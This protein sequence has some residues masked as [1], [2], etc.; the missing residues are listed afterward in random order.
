M[1]SSGSGSDWPDEMAGHDNSTRASSYPTSPPRHESSSTRLHAPGGVD[2]R[3]VWQMLRERRRFVFTVAAAVFALVMGYTA[4]SGMTFQAKGQLYLG[5]LDFNRYQQQRSEDFLSGGQGDVYSEIEIVRSRARVEQ[6]ILRSGLNVSI[7]PAESRTLPYWRWRWSRRD[8]GLLDARATVVASD[9]LPKSRAQETLVLRLRFAEL[10]RY[11]VYSEAGAEL[12]RGELGKPCDVPVAR[13]FL[14]AGPNGGPQPHS[15]YRVEIKPL[16][17][18]V[19]DAL[20]Q[21]Q[22]TAP[23][24]PT[25]SEPVKVLTL[26]F[27]DTSPHKA[28]AF[29]QQLMRVYLQERQS[30]KTED[31][32]AAESFVSKQLEGIQRSLGATEDRLADFR[33]KNQAVVQASQADAVVEQLAAYEQQRIA[34]RLSAKALRDIQQALQAPEPDVEK[35][36]IGEVEDTVLAQLAGGLVDA[37]RSLREMKSRLYDEAPEF[38]TQRTKVATQ[39]DMTRNYVSTRLARA[40]EQVHALDAVIKQYE[41]KLQAVPGAELGLAKIGR[42]SE[43][44]SRIYSYLLERQQQTQILKASTVSKNRILDAPEVPVREHSPKLAL[45]S[46]SALLGLLLGAIL[47]I[48]QALWSSAMRTA[49]EVRAALEHV[50]VFA[51]VPLQTRPAGRT[52]RL[53]ATPLFDVLARTRDNFGFA[54]AFRTLRTEI[55]DAQPYGPAKLVPVTSPSPGDGKTTTALALA[56][57]L[58][59]DRKRVLVIDADVRK[60]SHH[61]LTGHAAAPGLAEL[62]AGTCSESDATRAVHVTG[63]CFHSI[64]AGDGPAVELLSST[65]LSELLLRVRQHYDYVILDAASYPLVSDAL[66]LARHCEF[67]LSVIRLGKTSRR[68]AE[69]HYRGLVGKSATHALV[70]NDSDVVMGFGYPEYARAGGAVHAKPPRRQAR[71]AEREREEEKGAQLQ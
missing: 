8:P 53:A 30:W 3:H 63:G 44:Y 56:T 31:A 10:P 18:T 9:T 37:Q 48:V 41:E 70:I 2:A 7:T 47:V 58:A 50:P 62:L 36:L 25:A 22:V 66:I 28:A 39:L 20:R 71:T 57:I 35:F 16:A 64:P 40:Q 6:A 17:T 51:N 67:A 55:Y 42:E 12:G 38:V 4:L 43:V 5:E 14:A 33:A 1:R 21:L 26:E 32:S 27:T 60:P 69:D 61:L 52:A 68:L 59:V 65:E 13:L 11:V 54:E 19:D 29:L 23:K 15:S 24:V 46:A 49:A 34:A 45:R